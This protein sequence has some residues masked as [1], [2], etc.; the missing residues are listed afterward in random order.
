M[1]YSVTN[2]YHARHISDQRD[3]DEDNYERARLLDIKE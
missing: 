1:K 3:S 2:H